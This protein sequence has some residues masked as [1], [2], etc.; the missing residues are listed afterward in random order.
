MSSLP[1]EPP[2]HTR[3][4]FTYRGEPLAAR[5]DRA[6]ARAAHWQENHTWIVYGES[7]FRTWANMCE[8][9]GAQEMANATRW[10]PRPP[11]GIGSATCPGRDAYEHAARAILHNEG[12]HRDLSP[13]EFDQAVYQRTADAKMQ[14]AVEATWELAWATGWQA[15]RAH[16]NTNQEPSC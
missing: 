12:A 1:P 5:R 8:I 13:E 15:A 9:F 10:T 11:P 7:C 14:L 4:E 3:L 2:N 6:A 16:Q